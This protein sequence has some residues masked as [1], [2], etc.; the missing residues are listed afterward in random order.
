[1]KYLLYAGILGFAFWMIS[2]VIELISGYNSTVYYLTSGYHFFAGLGVW[3]LYKVQ[4]GHSNILGK[5]G[6]VISSLSYL[7][8]TLFPIQVLNSG[9]SFPEFLEANPLY[10]IEKISLNI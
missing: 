5:T 9:L 7:G 1:M 6:A 3:G 4:Q 10:K 8:L 2:E